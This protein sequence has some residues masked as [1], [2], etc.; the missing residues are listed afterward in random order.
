MTIGGIEALRFETTP[1]DTHTVT[2]FEDQLGTFAIFGRI[3]HTAYVVDVDET[4][5]LVV[6]E[7]GPGKTVI[8]A[9]VES[10]RWREA[11]P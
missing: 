7:Q 5:L 3:P 1:H 6:A 9:I 8:D 10:I 2:S 11:G 4:T